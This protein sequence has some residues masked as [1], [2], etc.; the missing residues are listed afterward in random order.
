MYC[1][2]DWRVDGCTRALSLSNR[3]WVW[4]VLVFTLL[5]LAVGCSRQA[6][7]PEPVPVDAYL[8]E[9]EAAEPAEIEVKSLPRKR[10][11]VVLVDDSG[12]MNWNDPDG[13][14]FEISAH[15]VWQLQRQDAVA[16]LLFGGNVEG[17]GGDR[18]PGLVQRSNA[19]AIDALRNDLRHAEK[20]SLS[21][22][23]QRRKTDIL[24]AM[25]TAVD[26]L[27]DPSYEKHI[28]LLTDGEMDVAG[29]H[30]TYGAD[31]IAA[32]DRALEL[33][34]LLTSVSTAD[35]ADPALIRVHSFG[36]SKE[37]SSSTEEKYRA[38]RRFLAELDSD[39]EERFIPDT[40][41]LALAVDE[42]LA[43][44]T[45][46]IPL[47]EISPGWYSFDTDYDIG[48]FTIT[49]RRQEAAQ[50]ITVLA[51]STADWRSHQD[52]PAEHWNW[53]IDR[54]V[55]RIAVD[56]M[57]MQRDDMYGQWQ[58]RYLKYG[59]D[60]Q[61]W[62]DDSV[63]ARAYLI[64]Y[65]VPTTIKLAGQAPPPSARPIAD[66]ALLA[67]G[68]S[69]YFQVSFVEEVLSADGSS[70]DTSEADIDKLR[71]PD[72]EPSVSV[73][74][75]RL[76]ED[77]VHA[78]SERQ[79]I[80]LRPHAKKPSVYICDE[81]WLATPG[82]W[83]A[84][85]I[86]TGFRVPR[87]EDVGFDVGIFKL[88]VEQPPDGF[89]LK[90]TG[91][92]QDEYAQ[93]TDW[94]RR[95]DSALLCLGLR[96][97]GPLEVPVSARVDTP[98]PNLRFSKLSL[99]HQLR[100]RSVL[101]GE[102]NADGNDPNHFS[103]VINIPR[104]NSAQ[105]QQL[106][107]IGD[108]ELTDPVRMSFVIEQGHVWHCR[109]ILLCVIGGVILLFFLFAVVHPKFIGFKM[110][111]NKTDMDINDYSATV[112]ITSEN[113]RI[114]KHFFQYHQRLSILG[115]N[116]QLKLRKY[117]HNRVGIT[118]TGIGLELPADRRAD[119]L[120]YEKLLWPQESCYALEGLEI[121]APELNMKLY[122]TL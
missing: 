23:E 103:A 94:E 24:Q 109:M 77:G 88:V 4:P 92:A 11:V 51:P 48:G 14:R 65:T 120:W 37:L 95:L 17:I 12:S 111:V 69:V 9:T 106:L 20:P 35:P 102:V 29:D 21:Q 114:R 19:P 47:T 32:Q 84:R 108:P 76:A 28:F 39:G 45:P 15:V 50:P 3:R 18:V 31:D 13:R 118:S 56:L 44:I 40:A 2:N 61:V 30:P 33:E 46:T 41:A 57:A 80:Q 66:G 34:R 43:Q 8:S 38:A 55:E 107:V 49:A 42:V 72:S 87:I 82:C 27:D 6:R 25:Q 79:V 52:F 86:K 36:F 121:A 58:I 16:V 89:V 90:F 85:G 73:E 5:F 54:D 26:L 68:R 59:T 10:A 83:T 91:L 99:V 119:K 110:L 64:P 70:I 96:P 78:A 101:C 104:I 53:E 117:A 22:Q 93:A 122:N 115:D 105:P 100:R 63:T 71:L 60:V 75:I 7:Q 67:E 62:P 98:H 81:P 116:Q 112:V 113:K 1:S 97:P 74:L